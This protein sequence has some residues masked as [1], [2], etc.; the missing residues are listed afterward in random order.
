MKHFRLKQR[1]VHVGRTFGRATFARETI[2][3][4]GI[5]LVGFQ[6]VVSVRAQFE[7]GANDV[8]AAARGHHFIVCRDERWTHDVALFQATAAA[9]ALLEIADE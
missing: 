7:R 1:Q 9:V 5:E 3:Q 4:R 2:A 8:G 6:W